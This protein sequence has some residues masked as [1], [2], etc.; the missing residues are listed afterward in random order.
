MLVEYRE[1]IAGLERELRAKR[2]QIKRLQGEQH[3]ALE[4][5]PEAASAREVLEYWSKVCAPNARE[6]G[7]DRL[8]AVISRLRGG[9]T[10]A[11]LIRAADGY[12]ALPYVVNGRRSPQGAPQHRQVEA[13][14]IY[15]GPA[16]VDR[17]LQYAQTE[18]DM[19]GVMVANGAEINPETLTAY[20][21]LSD[22]GQ[23]A[24][25]YA[26]AG[27]G[28]FP[29]RKGAKEPATK[30]GLLDA[31]IDPERVTAWWWRHPDDNVAIRCGVESGLVV[32]DVDGDDGSLALRGLEMEHGLL[33]TTASVVTPSGGQHYYFRHPGG[34]I[35]N[36]VSMVGVGL[37]IRGDGGYVVAPPSTLDS[38]FGYVLDERAKV[39]PMPEW[40]V[41]TIRQRQDNRNV[42]IDPGVWKSIVK[43]GVSAGSRNA[44]LTRLTGY[45]ISHHID[46]GVTFEIVDQVN[47]GSCRP[48]LA[49][50]EVQRIVESIVK[51]NGRNGNA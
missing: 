14:L 29:C 37:D 26:K 30:N 31:T 7:G 33:P 46:P 22:Q 51:I 44:Q 2:S 18:S 49:E 36:S 40:L 4:T 9:Y 38:G 3:A 48:P 11:E 34:E 39:A 21:T 17:G 27:W 15:R 19:E 6:L 50:R 35:R 25:R 8:A 13:T 5:K 41:K 28:V 12:A 20:D 43:D 16:Q 32:L 42:G 10:V 24:V 47:R 45:L 23:A 1:A